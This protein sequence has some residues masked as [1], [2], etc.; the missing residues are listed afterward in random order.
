[1]F[2][3]EGV[4]AVLEFGAFFG[5]DACEVENLKE[6]YFSLCFCDFLHPNNSFVEGVEEAEEDIEIF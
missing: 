6:L 5:F 3:E 1:M 2:S 4:Q